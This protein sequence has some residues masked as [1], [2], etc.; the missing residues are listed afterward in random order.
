MDAATHRPLPGIRI[1]YHDISASITD[2]AGNFSVKVP[3]YNVAIV[4][5]GDGYQI[6]EIALKGRKTVSSSLY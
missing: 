3:N 6:K 1:S 2:S 4:L 5:E